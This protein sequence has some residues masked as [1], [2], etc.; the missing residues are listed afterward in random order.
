MFRKKK[1]YEI[2]ALED[3]ERQ[4][5]R[6][7]IEKIKVYNKLRQLTGLCLF[8]ANET[9]GFDIIGTLRQG[10]IKLCEDIGVRCSWSADAPSVSSEGT[11][12]DLSSEMVDDLRMGEGSFV[13]CQVSVEEK[14]QLFSF[15]KKG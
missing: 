4:T 12:G 2:L 5:F 10:I 7:Q 3:L 13:S 6:L 11:Y 14:I 1:G 8:S 15:L 9:D